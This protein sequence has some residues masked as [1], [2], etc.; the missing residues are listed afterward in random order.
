M[1]SIKKVIGNK[2]SWLVIPTIFGLLPLLICGII[3][4]FLQNKFWIYRKII[5]EDPLTKRIH[6]Q[7]FIR[8]LNKLTLESYEF[9]RYH[10]SNEPSQ[11]FEPGTP[12]K[13]ELISD[14]I[15]TEQKIIAI[16]GE[17]SISLRV[18]ALVAYH[19]G[20]F[21]V[22]PNFSERR[23]E[24]I[25]FD[26]T[27]IYLENLD[28]DPEL[29]VTEAFFLNYSNAPHVWNKRRFDYDAEKEMYIQTKE[30]NDPV[31]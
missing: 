25:K 16:W 31:L 28:D 13:L 4:L 9:A 26:S 14:N 23:R 7:F 2:N 3:L 15:Q 17:D 1:K 10:E 6:Y 30:W 20:E 18:L 5:P 27:E 11:T 12:I 21:R 29:E 8:T 22:I 24:D 19:N